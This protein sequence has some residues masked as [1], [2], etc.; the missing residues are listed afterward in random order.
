LCDY[1]SEAQWRHRL[2]VLRLLR[3]HSAQQVKYLRKQLLRGNEFN[4]A[5][6][7]AS[8]ERTALLEDLI[9][10]S[11][12][13]GMA[14]DADPPV[15]EAAFQVMLERGKG[16]VIARANTLEKVLSNSLGELAGLRQRLAALPVGNW[17]DSRRDIDTQMRQLL[18]PGFMRDTPEAWLAQLPRY[19]KALGTRIERLPGQYAR[20]QGH[21]AVLEELGGR[22]WAAL[23][24]RPLLLRESEQAM[25]YRWLLEEFRVSLFAQSLGTR[26]PVSA[27]R[28]E[29]Q[30]QEVAQWLQHN[31]R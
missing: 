5:L 29:E 1:R 4:L 7:A 30:W 23:K 8:L 25:Q 18:S 12:L 27:K 10:A 31:P 20:D 6:A 16:E 2:G 14:V 28:L 21:S 9:D 11:Y 17:T 22:L 19:L 3:L 15:T 13:Q 26:Q 24:E